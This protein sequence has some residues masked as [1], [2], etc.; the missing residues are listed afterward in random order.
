[1]RDF[2]QNVKTRGS[3]WRYALRL[4][5]KLGRHR[6]V[7]II[8]AEL[9]GEHDPSTGAGECR[10]ASLISVCCGAVGARNVTITYPHEFD[11]GLESKSDADAIAVLRK[12][13]SGAD[14]ILLGSEV[15]NTITRIALKLLREEEP[16][17][18]VGC[19]RDAEGKNHTILFNGKSF[20]TEYINSDKPSPHTMTFD[21]G[22][23]LVRPNCFNSG[24][25]DDNRL[26]IFAGA[27]TYGTQA[28]AEIF[29][30]PE[31]AAQIA[32]IYRRTPDGK[33]RLFKKNFT[34]RIQ[35]TPLEKREGQSV[36]EMPLTKRRRKII[37]NEPPEL[38]GITIE[39]PVMPPTMARFF[40]YTHWGTFRAA[41]FEIF[42]LIAGLI[43]AAGIYF[44]QWMAI[45]AGLI[46]YVVVRFIHD[47]ND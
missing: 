31:G 16:E 43:L 38:A 2:Y 23:F 40:D 14:V 47:N 32:Q 21:H 6:P 27:H 35:V 8:P 7:I 25:G 15:T 17:L 37:I 26:F 5:K 33:T 20:S 45:G 36:L 4:W 29:F 28:A 10:S 46:F 3:Q 41:C 39:N 44:H 18:N 13:L 34:C 9:D 42:S 11:I 24:K 30:S 22:Y 1:M 12:E 19:S